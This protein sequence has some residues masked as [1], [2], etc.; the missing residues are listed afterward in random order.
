MSYSFKLEFI[1]YN[2]LE[3]TNRKIL[4]NVYRN[5]ILELIV[6]SWVLEFQNFVLK[7]DGNNRHKKA[8]N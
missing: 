7:K 6:K 2:V 1:F 3:N 8:H 5:K 4:L